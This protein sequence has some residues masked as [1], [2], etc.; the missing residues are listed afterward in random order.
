MALTFNGTAVAVDESQL[1][2]DYTKP[3]VTTIDAE[4]VTS[5]DQVITIAKTT[6]ENASHATMFGNIVTEVNTEVQS[7]IN[8][9]FD[10]TNTNFTAYATLNKVENDM[11]RN[12]LQHSITD[13]YASVTINVVKD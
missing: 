11:D 13:F 10:T 8:A 7:I 12:S 5:S 3:S 1:P 6:V 9:N 4:W 2:P